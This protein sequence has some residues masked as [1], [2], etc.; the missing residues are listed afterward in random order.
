MKSVIVLICYALSGVGMLLIGLGS[1]ALQTF[2]KVF[3]VVLIA[4]LAALV[5]HHRMSLAWVEG[6]RLGK[7]VSV[8]AFTL[9]VLGFLAIPLA[10]VLVNHEPVP[11]SEAFMLVL[12]ELLVMS[13]ATALAAYLNW[14]HA[15]AE[16]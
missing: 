9:G 7:R 3:L 2:G 6:R 11:P 14:Y 16:T 5:A 12:V 10:A 8:V 4:W 15:S 1:V 13:P